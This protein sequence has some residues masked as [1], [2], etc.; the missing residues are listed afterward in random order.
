MN[1]PAV[2]VPRQIVQVVV[3]AR[4]LMAEIRAHFDLDR[5]GKD[6]HDRTAIPG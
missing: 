2:D 1:P 4:A 6:S 5:R 3:E